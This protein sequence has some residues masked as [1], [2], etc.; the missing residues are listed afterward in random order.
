MILTNYG[1]S[2]SELV[3]AINVKLCFVFSKTNPDLPLT[4]KNEVETCPHAKACVLA[5]VAHSM[6]H[7]SI[8]ANLD[9]SCQC[10]QCILDSPT[11]SSSVVCQLGAGYWLFTCKG[12][13]LL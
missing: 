8:H 12:S 3:F 6:I 13:Y 11:R 10:L 2:N 7:S 9:S 4:V 5:E 1:K